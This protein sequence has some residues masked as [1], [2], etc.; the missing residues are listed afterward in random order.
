MVGTALCS[1]QQP[2]IRGPC[3]RHLLL[4]KGKMNY[5]PDLK[6]LQGSAYCSVP[7]A[8]NICPAC[9]M[10]QEAQTSMCSKRQENQVTGAH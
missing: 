6:T 3:L 4:E 2:T 8:H 10:G 7:G 5:M 1:Y 9:T